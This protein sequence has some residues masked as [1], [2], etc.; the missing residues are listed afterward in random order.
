L[1]DDPVRP[2]GTDLRE[3]ARGGGG[4]GAYD[5]Y[6]IS[7]SPDSRQIA[8]LSLP[9]G[10]ARIVNAN[11]TDAHTV[12]SQVYGPVAWSPDSKRLAII[13]GNLYTIDTNGRSRHL[14]ATG[15]LEYEYDP[16]AWA[17]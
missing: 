4:D 1:R 3:L 15:P 2:D 17:P 14:I 11:G 6:G 10:K 5:V 16:P 13:Q 7:W 9:G 8:Y 12:F